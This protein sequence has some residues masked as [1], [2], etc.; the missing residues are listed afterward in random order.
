MLYTSQMEAIWIQISTERPINRQETSRDSFRR[1]CEAFVQAE[2]RPPS[3]KLSREIKSFIAE[4]KI[5]AYYCKSLLSCRRIWLTQEVGD[6]TP[7]PGVDPAA[8]SPPTLNTP[9][10]VQSLPV[11]QEFVVPSAQ[12]TR[13]AAAMKRKL[14]AKWQ[15]K[16]YRR[17]YKP[18]FGWNPTTG[19]PWLAM[20]C[21]AKGAYLALS[22][23]ILSSIPNPHDQC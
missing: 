7:F 22:G 10:I 17:G 14:L 15:N 18:K 23:K 3:A 20:R 19:E 12:V 21:Y 13:A 4:R 2:E 5:W 16:P 9:L 11:Q 1:V 8:A 6:D